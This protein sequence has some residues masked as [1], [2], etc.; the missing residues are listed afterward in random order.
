MVFAQAI[1]EWKLLMA[2]ALSGLS[3]EAVRLAAAYACERVAFGR[4]IGTYQG[5]SHPLADLITD[6][7][8]GKYLVWKTIRDIADRDSRTPGRRYR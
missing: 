6:I 7:D 3:R 5:I 1:E 4:F 2:A 8:G